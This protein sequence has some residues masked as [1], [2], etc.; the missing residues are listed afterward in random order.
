MGKS[1]LFVCSDNSAISQI[2]ELYLN[3]LNG[4]QYD[5][6]SAGIHL[7]ELNPYLF[8]AMIQDGLLLPETWVKDIEYYDGFVFDL[9][10]L[11][12]GDVDLSHFGSVTEVW[13]HSFK[14][15]SSFKGSD[16]VVFKKITKLR[17][18]IKKWIIVKFVDDYSE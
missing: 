18:E 6:Y 16:E 11:F 4:D 12:C 13:R 2:A 7:E 14:D 1:V 10:V 9:V 15:P 8:E 17:D 5:A 3:K